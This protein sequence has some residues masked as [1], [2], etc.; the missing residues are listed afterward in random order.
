MMMRR[1]DLSCF[2]PILGWFPQVAKFLFPRS[3][4]SYGKCRLNTPYMDLIGYNMVTMIERILSF[5]QVFSSWPR[6]EA[7]FNLDDFLFSGSKMAVP[8]TVP[9]SVPNEILYVIFTSGSTGRPKVGWNVWLWQQKWTW[10]VEKLPES[11]QIAEMS[12][13]DVFVY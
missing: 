3:F 7:I 2:P 1:I 10:V 9:R 5:C 11:M 8:E 4:D 12:I 6:K 13:S